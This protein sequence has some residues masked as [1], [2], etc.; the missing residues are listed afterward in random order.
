MLLTNTARF[1]VGFVDMENMKMKKFEVWLDSGANIH[2]KYKATIYLADIGFSDDEWN[3]MTED[4]RDEV[5]HD[6][7][8]ERSDWGYREIE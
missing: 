6:I 7:A 3:E 5:M 8:F 1:L 4:Q 2:S